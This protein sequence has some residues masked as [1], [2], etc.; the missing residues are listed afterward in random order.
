MMLRATSVP[1]GTTG[2]L[3]GLVKDLTPGSHKLV[4]RVADKSTTSVTATLELVD[5]SI[6][7]P[8]FSG[9]HQTPFIC[10]TDRFTLPDGTILGPPL[11]ENCSAKTRVNYVYKSTTGGFKPL[12]DVKAQPLDL[13]QTTTSGGRTVR[14]HI[15]RVEM[16][17][18]RRFISFSFCTILPLTLIPIRLHDPQAGT[19]T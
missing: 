9:P 13:A 19:E 4:A 1:V 7:G 12:A 3:I 2:A 8:I 15:V 14:N 10:E 11:D 17:P 18:N 5:H 6:S 16:G